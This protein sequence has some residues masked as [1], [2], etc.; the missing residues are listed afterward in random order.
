MLIL[1]I[2]LGGDMK[3]KTLQIRVDGSDARQWQK[4][5]DKLGLTLSAW[6]RMR[7]KV[8]QHVLGAT[9]VTETAKHGKSQKTS[10]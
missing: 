10:K 3:N 6:I 8:D 4:E 7:L 1:N 2:L 5:A 9:G